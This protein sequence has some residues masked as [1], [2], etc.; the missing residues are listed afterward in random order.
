MNIRGE[1]NVNSQSLVFPGSVNVS[2]IKV[3]YNGIYLSP[4]TSKLNSLTGEPTV[5]KV[6]GPPGCMLLMWVSCP[7]HIWFN[8]IAA[9]SR[10]PGLFLC[11][12][13]RMGL[14]V[15]SIAL[16]TS[17]SLLQFNIPTAR[18]DEVKTRKY[19]DLKLGIK[20]KSNMPSG[21]ATPLTPDKWDN[22]QPGTVCNCAIKLT[23]IS[24]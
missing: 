8:P 6:K 22:L 21:H 4:C 13:Q 20:C 2:K 9:I 12:T 15:P 10:W 24:V 7:G 18:L 1:G 23:W 3:E 11:P 5:S 16:R 14:Q 19:Q 17:V